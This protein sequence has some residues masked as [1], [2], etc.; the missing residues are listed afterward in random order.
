LEATGEKN[1]GIRGISQLLSANWATGALSTLEPVFFGRN[2][3]QSS[4]WPALW[5]WDRQRD[6]KKVE[7]KKEKKW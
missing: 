4:N 3:K 7:N 6:K 1:G 5:S 2:L